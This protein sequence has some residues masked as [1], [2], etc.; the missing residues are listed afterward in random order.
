[1]PKAPKPEI[2]I[3]TSSWINIFEIGLHSYL[4][5]SFKVHTTPKVVDEIREGE[6]FA[7]DAR[8]FMDLM[9][10]KLIQVIQESKIPEEMQ[11]FTGFLKEWE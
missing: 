8:I 10:K 4:V 3:N 11:G 9:D 6:D 1:M 2:L 7:P 5:E